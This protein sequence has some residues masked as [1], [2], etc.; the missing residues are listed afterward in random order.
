MYD[1]T[2][3]LYSLWKDDFNGNKYYR[4][5]AN[6]GHFSEAVHQ[7][8]FW[9]IHKSLPDINYELLESNKK[10]F[11]DEVLLSNILDP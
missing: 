9:N 8:F 1:P 11:D 2:V 7:K 10:L 6:N 3:C 5:G 4:V